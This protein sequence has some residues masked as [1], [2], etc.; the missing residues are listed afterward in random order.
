MDRTL[1][2]DS[3]LH[4]DVAN[5]TGLSVT[6]SFAAMR[7]RLTGRL[8]KVLHNSNSIRIRSQVLTPVK[9]EGDLS[10]SYSGARSPRSATS[11]INSTFPGMHSPIR[12]YS[13]SPRT[14][15]VR[16]GY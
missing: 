6:E 13:V 14:S 7:S 16:G 3:M 12:H 11:P 10:R 4:S 15:P 1:K 9:S 8:Q 2:E 5:R